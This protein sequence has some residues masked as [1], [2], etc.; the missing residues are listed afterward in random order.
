MIATLIQDR[1]WTLTHEYVL[2]LILDSN[3]LET[4]ALGS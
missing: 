3:D 2:P 1:S 4:G